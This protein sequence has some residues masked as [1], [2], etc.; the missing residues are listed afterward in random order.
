VPNLSQ[1]RLI[2]ASASPRRVDLLRQI[3]II[4]NQIIPAYIDETPRRNELP[5]DYALR[6]AIEKAGRIAE[7]LRGQYAESIGRADSTGPSGIFVL[8]GDTVVAA[9]RRILPKV[10]SSQE[11]RDCLAILSGRRHRVYGGVALHM[12]NGP[13]RHRLVQSH[14]RFRRLSALDIDQYIDGGD[15]RGMA[16][17]YAI[18]GM[19]ARFIRDIGGSYSNIV[20]LSIYD[21]AAM[22]DAAGWHQAG[23]NVDE[24][25]DRKP[26]SRSK[27][28]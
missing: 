19:A 14:V 15:W 20:G 12:L 6:M 27:G 13:L 1:Y 26:L 9:G 17:G 7:K 23:H 25:R 28:L 21:V 16:G 10:K 11:A 24:T 3:Q 4:P 2:L 18:Q 22:L 5:A 8:A